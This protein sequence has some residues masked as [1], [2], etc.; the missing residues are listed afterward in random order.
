M[1]LP[2]GVKAEDVEATTENGVLEVT[3]PLPKSA[4]RKAVEI[5]PKAK[6]D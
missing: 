6:S 3:V 5:K 1:A 4:E 2:A